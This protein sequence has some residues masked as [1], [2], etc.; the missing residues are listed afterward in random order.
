MSKLKVNEIDSKT[1]TTVT[2]TTGK[3]LDIPAGGTISVAGT[4]TVS[5]TQTISGTQTVTGTTNLSAATLTLPAT[6]PAT[7]GTNIT[8]L[9]AAN[10]TGTLPAN[11]LG[12]VPSQTALLNDIATLALHSAT[13]NNQ[14]A[15]NLSNA[16]I[17]QYEDSTGLDVL[18]NT[19]RNASEYVSTSTGGDGTPAYDS[20]DRRS[21]ITVTTDGTTTRSVTLCVDGSTSIGDSFYWNAGQNN[22]YLRFQF[23]TT[24]KITGIRFTNDESGTSDQGTWKWQGSDNGSSWTDIGGT[25]GYNNNTMVGGA[26]GY[27]VLGDT[28]SGNTTSYIYYLSLIH[29]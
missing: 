24:K 5:G 7:I 17:D 19:F 11:T 25:F 26:G 9:P 14:T 23:A 20:G 12:N 10:V 22:K 2:V 28:L 29:I 16:F 3:T 6:L 1:G 13:Q 27:T 21:T 8:Q 15:Y 18:T 4:Q